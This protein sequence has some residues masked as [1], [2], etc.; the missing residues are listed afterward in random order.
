MELQ[1]LERMILGAHRQPV[2]GRIGR[3]PVRHR[4][5]RQHPLM[6]QPQIPVQPRSRMLLHDEPSLPVGLSG[7]RFPPGLGR[8]L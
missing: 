4:P 5:R 1:I 8:L 2:V 7:N 3:D 6:L